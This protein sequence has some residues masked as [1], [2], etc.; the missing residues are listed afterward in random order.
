MYHEPFQ[1]EPSGK[2]D[3]KPDGGGGH[4][5][6]HGAVYCTIY[7]RRNHAVFLRTGDNAAGGRRYA[8]N[9]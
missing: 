1:K 5:S 2:Q 3:Q 4:Y 9:L 7:R 8:R 6:D